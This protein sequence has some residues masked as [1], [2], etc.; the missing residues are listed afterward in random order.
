VVE[1]LDALAARWALAERRLYPGV[2]TD[3]VGYERRLLAV[4][5][6]ADELSALPSPDALAAEFAGALPRAAAALEAVGGLA[7]PLAA[8]L[9]A[10][11]AFALAHRG[12]EASAASAQ[13]VRRIAEAARSGA[14]WVV[15]A[16]SG[17]PAMAAFGYYRRL[18]M[19]LPDGMGVYAYAEWEPDR[20]EPVFVLE[21]LALDPESGA[22]R[23]EPLERFTFPAP[24]PWEA[25]AARLRGAVEH[26]PPGS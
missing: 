25:A 6:L 17:Q 4:R 12:L 3:P 23:G 5:T 9:V 21:H 2:L 16:E 19:H 13:R 20:A 11:A 8:E 22:A 26:A 18:E 10:G 7:D 15:V 14:S 1:S 24:E